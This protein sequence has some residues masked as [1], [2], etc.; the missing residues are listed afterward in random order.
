MKTL[1]SA[2]YKRHDAITFVLFIAM[3]LMIAVVALTHQSCATQPTAHQIEEA[4][5]EEFL[6]CSKDEGDWGCDSCFFKVFGYHAEEAGY[7]R[8]D[9]AK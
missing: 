6:E 5:W 1:S 8:Y 3:M 7:L 2:E 9:T 4:K